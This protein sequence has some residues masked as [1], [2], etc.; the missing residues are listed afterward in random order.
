M[1][2]SLH[3]AVRERRQ[4]ERVDHARAGILGARF[5]ETPHVVGEKEI[6][7]VEKRDPFAMGRV[8]SRVGGHRAGHR[9]A[10]RNELHV[11][12][13]GAIRGRRMRVAAGCHEHHFQRIVLRGE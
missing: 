2:E 11:V 4:R 6:V 8:E 9:L 3:P 10:A 1:A 7:V 5:H 13:P 12:L